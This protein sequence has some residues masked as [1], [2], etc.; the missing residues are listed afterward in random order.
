MTNKD[1]NCC[2]CLIITGCVISGILFMTMV[3]IPLLSIQEYSVTNCSV[4]ST[5]IPE[6]LPNETY[7]ENWVNCDCGRRCNFQTACTQIF[8]NI[9]NGA[10]GVLLYPYTISWKNNG[11]QCTFNNK[12]CDN[13]IVYMIESMETAR[14]EISSYDVGESFACFTDN[15]RTQAFISNEYTPSEYLFYI[16]ALLCFSLVSQWDL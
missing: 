5:E 15:T 16:I 9:E 3:L 4:H 13:D 7:S 14:H 11:T 12:F 6:S 10:Q 1:N 8:V 2:G